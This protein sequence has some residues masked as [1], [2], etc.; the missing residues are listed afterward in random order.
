MN[1]EQFR[2][3]LKE[4]LG[5]TPVSD[6][7]GR[8]EAAVAGPRSR[9]R[10]RPIGS[11]AATA[12]I[13]LVGVFAGWRLVDQHRQ[14]A[15]VKAGVKGI[16]TAVPSVNHSA[17]LA[18]CRMPVVVMQ[19]SGPPGQLRNEAGFIDTGTGQ[20]TTDRSASVVGLPGG[21]FVGS[22]VKPSRP[23]T[24][25][26]FSEILHRW[27][28]VDERSISPDGKSYVW[29]RLLPE[30]SNYSNFAKAELHRYDVATRTD[31]T[32]WTYAGSIA[33]NGWESSGIQ[34]D[35]EPASSGGP[36]IGWLIDPATGSAAQQPTAYNAPPRLTALPGD[37]LQNG[38]FA[39]GSIPGA[40]F[41]GHQLWRIGS[42]QSGSPELVVYETAPGQRITI[43]QGAQGDAMHFDPDRGLA[44][45]MGIWFTDY[46][47]NVLW[48]WQP[49]TGLRKIVLTG[50]PQPISGPN[51]GTYLRPA[52]TCVP[53]P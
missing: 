53:L 21:A 44:D 11:L 15:S 8:I 40:K 12:A 50:L 17:N 5:S 36:L 47:G 27:L 30:G 46:Q 52:G 7:S 3:R 22:D 14:P 33:I 13:L 37:P 23:A 1:E 32:L 39:Y 41:R 10:L 38:G 2:E 35:T 42:R 18:V 29:E 24:P 25:A 45:V 49:Q 48:R 51:S 43:Y 16:P 9:P 6:L 26:F 31:R 28:P 19:E 4:A 34:V 20:Y